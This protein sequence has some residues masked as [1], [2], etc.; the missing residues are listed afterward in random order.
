MVYYKKY[1]EVRKN[2]EMIKANNWKEEYR[3]YRIIRDKWEFDDRTISKL[4]REYTVTEILEWEFTKKWFEPKDLINTKWL[5]AIIIIALLV[6]T[7]IVHTFI[8]PEPILTN[9]TNKIWK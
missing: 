7:T 3:A 1:Y 6:V 8:L 5:L 9:I 2:K 4:L